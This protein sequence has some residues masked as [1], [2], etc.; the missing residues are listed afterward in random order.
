MPWKETTPVAERMQSLVDYRSGLFTVSFLAERHGVS[1]KTLYKW[2]E[3]FEREG[4]A[5]L[6]DQLRRPRWHPNQTSEGVESAIAEFRRKHPDWGPKKIVHV[7]STRDEETTW[8]ARST[9]AAILKRHG[10]VKGRRRRRL[11]GHPGRPTTVARETNELWATDFKGEF[12]TSDGIYCYPLTVTDLFSR[13]LVGCKGLLSTKTDGVKKIFERLFREYGLP[14]AI[15]SDNGVPFASTGLGRLSRLSV[16]WIKLGIRPELTQPAHPE[17]NGSHERM[18]RTLKR[19]T[20][21]PVGRDLRGQQKR[22]DVFQQEFNTE[23]PH[24][25]IGMKRPA[26]LY[27]PSPRAFPS[28]L[29]RI[30]YP[31]HFEVRRVSRNGGIRWKRGWL[32]VSHPLID[33]YVGLEEVDDGVWNLYFGPLLLGRFDERE[34]KLYA[35]FYAH[36]PWHRGGRAGRAAHA[37]EQEDFRA[38]HSATTTR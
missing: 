11:V 25:S 19:A 10:L 12:R 15:R 2:I 29:A 6:E 33:E 18:H 36:R 1:R 34:E 27:R 16:W 5:G 35:A 14:R 37:S 3:R 17:Q 38:I 26:D 31:G 20:T 21:R 23:R 9:V 30:E 13:Y 8:P 24:E 4:V 22:F 28:V 32:N 7:L